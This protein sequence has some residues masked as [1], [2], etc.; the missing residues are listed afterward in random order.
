M[1]PASIKEV[2]DFVDMNDIFAD[3]SI[4]QL[5]YA[6][7]EGSSLADVVEILSHTKWKKYCRTEHK[8]N[9]QIKSQKITGIVVK[10]KQERTID[11]SNLDYGDKVRMILKYLFAGEYYVA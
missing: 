5:L 11:L 4:E 2:D 9:G 6:A 1:T 7:I 3:L 10:G 8:Y